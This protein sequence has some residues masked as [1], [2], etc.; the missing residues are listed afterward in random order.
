MF[1]IAIELR[2]KGKKMKK[3]DEEFLKEFNRRFLVWF[4]EEVSDYLDEPLTPTQI[5]ILCR[6]A[7]SNGFI[8]GLDLQE[9]KKE[10]LWK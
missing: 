6:A 1:L 4:D 7:W 2:L 9:E 10:T 5:K 3:E 8:V